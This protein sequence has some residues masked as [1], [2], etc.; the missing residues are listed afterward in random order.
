MVS[1]SRATARI[2][3]RLRQAPIRQPVRPVRVHCPGLPA[4][5]MQPVHTELKGLS[6]DPG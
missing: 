4:M 5:F 1:C 6:T 2:V 3:R